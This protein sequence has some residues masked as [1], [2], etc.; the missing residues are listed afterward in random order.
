MRL[1]NPLAPEARDDFTMPGEIN[2]E[3]GLYEAALQAGAD[4]IRRPKQAPAAS[5]A[6]QHQKGRMTVWERIDQLVDE[7]PTILFQNWGKT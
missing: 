2:R 5:V 3:S 4:L 6:R 7:P 1:K